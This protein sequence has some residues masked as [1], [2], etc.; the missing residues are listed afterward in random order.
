MNHREIFIASTMI[1]GLLTSSAS[2]AGFFKWV[3]KEAIPAV[4]GKRPPKIHLD[5]VTVTHKGK[6]RIEL[7]ADHAYVKIGDVSIKTHQLRKRLAQA[8]CI[9]ATEGNVAYCAP[10]ILDRELKNIAKSGY[11]LDEPSRPG[12]A[13]S[14]DRQYENIRGEAIRKVSARQGWQTFSFWYPMSRI[15][16]IEGGWSVDARN[17]NFVGPKG[18]LGEQAKRLSPHNVRKYDINFP[19]GTLF[20]NINGYGFRN[21]TGP[22]E[23][24]KPVSIIQMRINDRD[25]SLG[26]NRGNLRVYFR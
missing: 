2:D 26:D 9:I 17:Y 21:V 10:D 13:D 11:G 25:D 18:H 1:I 16:K 6:K 14:L 4:T 8:G 3:K 15:I 20:V 22:M 24:P 12:R 5:R 19:F 23:F 7:G